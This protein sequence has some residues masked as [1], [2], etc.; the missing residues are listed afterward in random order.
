MK[1][2][3]LN[4]AIVDFVWKKAT[5]YVA[6]PN[7]HEPASHI[8]YIYSPEC[9]LQMHAFIDSPMHPI[10]HGVITDVMELVR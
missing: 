9:R 2:M 7:E 5:D 10:F 8:P 4:T 1:S 6:N 3:G